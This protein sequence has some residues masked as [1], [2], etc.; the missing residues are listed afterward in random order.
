VSPRRDRRAPYRFTV[1][2]R[3]ARP[4]GVSAADGCRGRVSVHVGRR[5]RVTDLRRSCTLRVI[6]R[7]PRTT[8][9]GRL[10][11]RATFTGN[12]ALE[13]RAARSVMVRVG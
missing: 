12:A 9:R 4:A 10:R 5:E 6:V 2:G 1:T 8:R 7:L 13:P 11:L 3:L